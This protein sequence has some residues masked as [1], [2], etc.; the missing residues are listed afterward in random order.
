MAPL[1]RDADVLV[2]A[3]GISE[4]VRLAKLASLRHLRR[5]VVLSSAGVYSAHRAS[6]ATYLDAERALSAVHSSAL[7][8]RPTMIYGSSRDRNIHHVI[9]FA[10]RF[11]VLPRIG[12]GSARLQPIHFADLSAAIC[13]LSDDGPHGTLDA[14]GGA[15]ISLLGLLRTVFAA[16]E[17]PARILP[18]PMLPALAAARAVDHLV[19]GRWAERVERMAEERTVDIAKLVAYTGLNPRSFEEGVRDEV[20]QMRRGGT[21][22]S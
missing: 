13:A 5:L 15:P 18:V 1:L 17:L 19:G 22:A 3:A 6:A 9:E 14:G 11:G 4:G 20:A 2:H 12:S 8:V 10:K 21:L 7:F 16:L